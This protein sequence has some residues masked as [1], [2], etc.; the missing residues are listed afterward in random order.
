MRAWLVIGLLA[1]SSTASASQ[2]RW[3]HEWHDRY[4]S[5]RLRAEIRREV[6]EAMREARRAMADARR[7]FYRASMHAR[8]DIDREVWRARRDA[9]REM[10]RA[11]READ[12]AWRHDHYWRD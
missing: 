11:Q 3:D 9:L 2:D 5:G 8:R 6:D 10:R 7:D 4:R 12:R 1:I